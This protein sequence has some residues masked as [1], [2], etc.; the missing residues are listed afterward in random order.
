METKFQT[1]NKKVSNKSK[2]NEIDAQHFIKH[3]S[4]TI[5][6][7]QENHLTDLPSPFEVNT[8]DNE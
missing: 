6:E 4:E 3:H 7:K 5:L 8:A 2:S 1:G